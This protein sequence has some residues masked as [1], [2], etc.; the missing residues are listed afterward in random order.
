MLHAMALGY[1][2]ILEGQEQIQKV[3]QSC[4]EPR[5]PSLL[6]SYSFII[7]LFIYLFG[8]YLQK[9]LLPKQLVVFQRELYLF[10]FKQKFEQILMQLIIQQDLKE[11]RGTDLFASAIVSIK[12]FYLRL[13]GKD[14]FKFHAMVF[15]IPNNSKSSAEILCGTTKN[16]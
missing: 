9:K 8:G 3:S 15:L 2:Q 10:L 16:Q 14:S 1:V 13:F 4:L 12:N 11:M 6:L 7:Y 5:I